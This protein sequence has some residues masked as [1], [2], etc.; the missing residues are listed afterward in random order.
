MDLQPLGDRLIVEANTMSDWK[1]KIEKV[2]MAGGANFDEARAR[3]I[4]RVANEL[5]VSV[6]VVNAADR[7]GMSPA[8]VTKWRAIKTIDDYNEM[9]KR[10]RA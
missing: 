7:I 6:D 3:A 8:D 9:R 10:E 4:N 5:G 1:V 2:D